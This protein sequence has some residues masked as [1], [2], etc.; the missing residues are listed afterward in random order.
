MKSKGL[1]CLA[2]LLVYISFSLHKKF[3]S[4]VFFTLCHDTSLSSFHP[5]HCSDIASFIGQQQTRFCNAQACAKSL[6]QQFTS[7]KKITLSFADG[8]YIV[9][10]QAARPVLRVNTDSVLTDAGQLAPACLWRQEVVLELP[11]ITVEDTAVLFSEK[12]KSQLKK[13]AYAF[14]KQYAITWFD[15]SYSTFKSLSTPTITVIGCAAT[16]PDNVLTYVTDHLKESLVARK[17]KGKTVA[18]WCIDVRFKNQMIVY[19]GGRS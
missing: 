12:Y 19:L 15:E 16:E 1:L 6:L 4:P 18:Q 14:D 2:L 5:D 3:S 10:A 11:S 7:L 8:K 9:H 17:S 13:W